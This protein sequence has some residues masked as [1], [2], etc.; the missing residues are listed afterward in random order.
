MFNHIA[1]IISNCKTA[2]ER[3]PWLECAYCVVTTGGDYEA[4]AH[5]S[6]T[7]FLELEKAKTEIEKT[8]KWLEEQ[9]ENGKYDEWSSIDEIMLWKINYAI[10]KRTEL[11]S[12]ELDEETLKF[13]LVYAE[14]PKTEYTVMP[15]SATPCERH[16]Y[17]VLTESATRELK[18][19][20]GITLTVPIIYGFK[21][22]YTN[23][24]VS[25]FCLNYWHFEPNELIGTFA[26]PVVAN[27]TEENG[28]YLED[29]SIIVGK[30]LSTDGFNDVIELEIK[31]D[32]KRKEVI[33]IEA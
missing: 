18:E 9:Y 2:E 19:K 23:R 12:Y 13:N 22:K 27:T 4:E 17:A 6:P 24:F 31:T 5:R 29:G 21:S 32:F 8:K 11:F 1:N 26:F 15:M 14:E 16:V 28:V 20:Y 33:L 10:G 25:H 3:R 7:M 30:K